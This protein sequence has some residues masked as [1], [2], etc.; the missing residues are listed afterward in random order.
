MKISETKKSETNNITFK[1]L[2]GPHWKVSKNLKKRLDMTAPHNVQIIGDLFPTVEV[3]ILCAKKV[4]FY[5][6]KLNPLYI[7]KPYCNVYV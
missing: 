3:W 1:S 5:L 4:Q 6:Q 7:E 2:I